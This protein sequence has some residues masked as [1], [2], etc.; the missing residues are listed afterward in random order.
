M[1][2][3]DPATDAAVAERALQL[4]SQPDGSYR[5]AEILARAGRSAG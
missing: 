1:L 5:A 3:L 4:A 2:V